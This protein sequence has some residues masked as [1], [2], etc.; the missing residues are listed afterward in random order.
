MNTTVMTSAFAPVTT[1][2]RSLVDRLGQAILAGTL[3][4]T[5]PVEDEL[6]ALF[7]VSRNS[8]RE[9]VKALVAKGLLDVR[10]RR[11]TTVR[12]SEAWNRLD[13]DVMR[14]WWAAEPDAVV[15]HV[16]DLRAIIEP[17][18]AEKAASLRD[19]TAGRVLRE[20]A[21]LIGDPERGA[22]ADLA[23]HSALLHASGNPLLGGVG[24]ALSGLLHAVFECTS[25]AGRAERAALVHRRLAEAVVSGDPASARRASLELLAA[26]ADDFAATRSVRSDV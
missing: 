22:A 20:S 3:A 18:A 6:A 24:A 5:L 26:A 17:A 4:G 15:R 9:A 19:A 8:L 10:P 25:S 23:F 16:Q 12:P 2:H 7:D 14:W 21:A 13:P 11:G 1:R